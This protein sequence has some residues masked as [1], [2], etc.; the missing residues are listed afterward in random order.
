MLNQLS[1][2]RPIDIRVAL[3]LSGNTD[4]VSHDDYWAAKLN[5]ETDYLMETRCTNTVNLF[6]HLFNLF[7]GQRLEDFKG[8]NVFIFS[9]IPEEDHEDSITHTGIVFHYE[10]TYIVVDSYANHYSLRVREFSEEDFV[11]YFEAKLVLYSKNPSS[12]TWFEITG[13]QENIVDN[14]YELEIIIYQRNLD[15]DMKNVLREMYKESLRAIEGPSRGNYYKKGSTEYEDYED[16]RNIYRDDLMA[17][18]LGGYGDDKHEK[19]YSM[20]QELVE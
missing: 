5:V 13:V 7:G 6:K 2:I 3:F 18:V 20:L 12:S 10:R 16:T 9:L 8:G 17:I 1:Y 19:T 11:T 4:E 14:D 15:I